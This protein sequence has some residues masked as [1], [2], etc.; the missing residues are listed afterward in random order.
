MRVAFPALAPNT[1]ADRIWIQNFADKLK[2]ELE[3]AQ[4]VRVAPAPLTAPAPKPDNSETE[5]RLKD[6]QLQNEQSQSLVEKYKKII[7]D[8]VSY[9]VNLTST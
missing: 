6:L 8:T 4:T 9:F 7:I 2:E 1:S 5:V 3:K